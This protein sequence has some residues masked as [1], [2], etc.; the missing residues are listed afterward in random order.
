LTSWNRI[1]SPVQVIR[2]VVDF[3]VLLNRGKSMKRA[4]T[5]PGTPKPARALIPDD[6]DDE[7]DDDEEENLQMLFLP[8]DRNRTVDLTSKIASFLTLSD[9]AA[10]AASIGTHPVYSNEDNDDD[11]R[12]DD[13]SWAVGSGAGG[14][15]SWTSLDTPITPALVALSPG[16]T[17]HSSAVMTSS[18]YMERDEDDSE[19]FQQMLRQKRRKW[20]Q[21][22]ITNAV[23]AHP[24][25]LRSY[26]C[27]AYLAAKAIKDQKE[28]QQLQQAITHET[29]ETRIEPDMKQA[30]LLSRKKSPRSGVNKKFSNTAL[31]AKLAH[32]IVDFVFHNV[33]VSVLLD[34]LEATGVTAAKTIGAS[35]TV[36]ISSLQK[37]LYCLGRLAHSIWDALAYCVTNPFQ[38][39][40]T[41]ISLQF[42][43]MGKTS[44]VIVGGIQ[45][46]A[47]GVGSASSL[48]LHKMTASHSNISLS[49]RLLQ[50][51][52]NVAAVE[53]RRRTNR[54]L[55]K[56]L[57]EIN[58][59]ALVVDYREIG[60]YDTAGL[61]RQAVS[62]ARR[63][64]HYSVSL[65]PFVATVQVATPIQKEESPPEV[66]SNEYRE[67]TSSV[68]LFEIT[69]A[70]SEVRGSS[71][72][73]DDDSPFMCTPQSFPPTPHSRQI[74]IDQ[75]SLMSDE[76][77]FLARDRL[78]V[79]GALESED[80]RTRE[81]AQDLEK[82][83]RLAIFAHNKHGGIELTCGAHIATK[84]GNMCYASTRSMVSI[85]RNCF[86][87][88]EMTVIPR[89]V[90]AAVTSLS[91]GLSTEEMPPNTLVGAWQGS[92]GLCSTGQ[93]LLAGQWCSPADP[94]S[95]AYGT[96]ATVGCLVYLD[97]E[98][99]FE[100]WDG[101]MIKATSRFNVNG[102]IIAPPVSTFP[103]AGAPA[104]NQSP[105]MPVVI[106][107]RPEAEPTGPVVFESPF[108]RAG[109]PLATLGLLVP[110]TAELY[111][112]VTLQ[113]IATS[114]VCRF[115]SEDVLASNREV[116]GAPPGVAVYAVDGSVILQPDAM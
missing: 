50:S 71:S 80:E 78:R 26:C 30:K 92:V 37:L 109:T 41:I 3:S 27:E 116:I 106:P 96:G 46:V 66:D 75:R 19:I 52:E 38:L 39:L 63:M 6:P 17:P 104:P 112:T 14:D 23:F 79:H 93:I 56:K 97:D 73:E 108:T 16:A 10:V 87:Y 24:G 2:T 65:R 22:K 81:R 20:A 9:A 5:F 64:M 94:L 70:T 33:P 47:S 48:A 8:D 54:R 67:R 12:D 69:M 45:S 90:E 29:P 28:Q 76:V 115:S 91:I 98:S 84:T 1:D 44:E 57:S 32:E 43:A 86:V 60:D 102:R 21:A 53:S 99:T 61:T 68:S 18:N 34:V 35:F 110:E 95:C 7:N 72:S 62:R 85:L 36:S 111:P 77:V 114:V 101:V 51:E 107:H 49:S 83:K 15:D 4:R 105:T 58:D 31:H 55:L 11:D 40:E 42:N 74:V 59:A 103:M 88:F 100:T 25:S 89:V 13:D 113:S 82:E